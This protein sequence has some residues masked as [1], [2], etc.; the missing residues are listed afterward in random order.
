MPLKESEASI[1]RSYPLC[2]GDRLVSFLS[3]YTSCRR[4]HEPYDPRHRL[5]HPR[6]LEA[7]RSEASDQQLQALLRSH[8]RREGLCRADAHGPAVH[9]L[10][11]SGAECDR[12]NAD[13]PCWEDADREA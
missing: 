4:A 11:A 12:A 7:G 8:R 3:R 6:Y 1:L 10:P 13:Y 5:L 9:E 2:E